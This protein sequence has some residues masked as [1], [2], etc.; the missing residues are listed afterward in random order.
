[1]KKKNPMTAR[2]P[3]QTVRRSKPKIPFQ[4]VLDEL[5]SEQPSVR[6]MFGC[7]AIYIEGKIT[8]ILRDRPGS[9]KDNGVWL[10]TTKEHHESLKKLFPFMRS[11]AVLG[12]DITGWQVLPLSSDDFESSVLKACELVRRRDPR[13]GKV[14]TSKR[15]APPK[16]RK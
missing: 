2:A 15:H 5:E 11:I 4:F 6:A 1:M 7:Y 12:K 10:A 14:P 8:L 9:P 3:R 13:I 16:H